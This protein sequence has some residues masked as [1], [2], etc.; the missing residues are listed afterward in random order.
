MIDTDDFDAVLE[1]DDNPLAE[2]VS[3]APRLEAQAPQDREPITFE[4]RV[5]DKTEISIKGLT[6]LSEAYEGL[7]IGLDDRV[8]LVVEARASKVDHYVS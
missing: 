4:G 7:R 2:V 1:S 5:V 3:A 8:R 6:G